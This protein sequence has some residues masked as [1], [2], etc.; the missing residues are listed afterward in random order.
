MSNSNLVGS[1]DVHFGARQLDPAAASQ[2]P[3][4]VR[5]AALSAVCPVV[6]LL[7]PN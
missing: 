2:I 5:L 4:N 3:R 6:A 7:H 1:D